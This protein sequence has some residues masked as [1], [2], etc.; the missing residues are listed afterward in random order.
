VAYNALTRH[1]DYFFSRLN[2]SNTFEQKASAH[3]GA[4]KTLIE[5]R[6]GL[7]SELSPICFLQGSY[8]HETAIYTI[9]DVDI[10]ALCGLWQPGSASGGRFWDR[11][12][13]FDTIAAPLRNSWQYK[14]KV[15]YNG[16]SMC[17]KL[18]VEPKIEILPVVYKSGNDDP[19][20]EPFR[21]YRPEEN[22]WEDG[23][24]RYHR[25]WLSWKNGYSKTENNFIPAI[26]I[27]KHLRSHYSLKAVS[28]HVECLLFSFP[29]EVFLG[30][31]ADYLAALLSHIASSSAS[32]W[33]QQVLHTPCKDRD[34]FTS[35]EW[36]RQEWEKFHEAATQWQRYARL[37]NQA[38][39]RDD[40]ID[41]W[42]ALLGANFFP[43]S[44]S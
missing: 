28:F 27:F 5:D 12:A 42:Q 7:A 34:I 4:V 40:A 23:Y 1:F 10:V 3:Y 16:Q 26:K 19:D 9:N 44:V 2:P 36:Q 35:S 39:D 22:Q 31:P 8:R 29:D 32:S 37:A 33:Y 38:V 30:G 14:G 6:S 41:T 25:G 15:R 18:D 21:L 11:D 24:A 20:K 43:K 17:V 13:I